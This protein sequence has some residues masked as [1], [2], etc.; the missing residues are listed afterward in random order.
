MAR[1]AA[2]HSNGK[3]GKPPRRIFGANGELHID[4][5]ATKQNAN[6]VRLLRDGFA[7]FIPVCFFHADNFAATILRTRIMCDQP[8]NSEAC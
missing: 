1:A 7:A 6:I 2:G 4:C 3:D 5:K 8:S